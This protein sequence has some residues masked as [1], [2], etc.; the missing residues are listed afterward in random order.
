M[1][2]TISILFR[3]IPL[4][5]GAVCL[6]FGLYILSGSDDA[7]H[8]VAG[9]VNVALT[10][11]CIALFTTAATIIRQLIHRY[12]EVWEVLLPAL[13][14]A[15]AAA[16]VIWGIIVVLEG[17]E[18]QH[19]VAGHVMLGIGFIA[20]C[21]STV[22]AA[23]TKFVLIAANGAR[24]PDSGPPDGAYSRGVGAVLIAI[25][26]VLAVT[27]LVIAAT[28]YARGTTPELV[29]AHVLTG[30]SLICAAL[31]ALVASI[32][33]Q[34]RN[35][36]GDA[37]RFR[38]TWWV[39]AMGTINVVVGIGVLLASDDPARLAP[40]TV[41]IGLGLIC[42]SIL[43]KVVLLA[44]VW[45][46]KFALANR[47]PI[48][49]IGTALACLFF[50]AFLFEATTRQAGYFVGAHVLVGLGAV[51]FTLFSIVSILEAGTSES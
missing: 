23:S 16:T 3:A 13:G 24:S 9:H 37:E 17:D 49:P 35:E 4:A 38:W 34:V 30:L 42:F 21:V 47:I 10:A 48:I 27:G 26:A 32:V 51:C 28:L 46:R 2:R 33:R 39:V 20:A 43:S 18:A 7:A 36:F 12:G 6:A 22:A 8:F 14:Y 50:A 40:G 45:R 29:A 11:I 44:L 15:V 19:V 31:V 5:M 41:L 25:P 1:N